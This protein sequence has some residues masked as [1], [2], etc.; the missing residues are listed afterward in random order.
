[1]RA[2]RRVWIVAA[3]AVVLV[4][5]LVIAGFGPLV[6]A[7]AR[8]VAARRGLVALVGTARP[9]WGRVW[10]DDVRISIP[11]VPAV[12]VRLN[13]VELDLSMFLGVERII[14]HGGDITLSGSPDEVAEQ[15]R[16][17]RR[18][19]R[20]GAGGGVTSAVARGLHLTWRDTAP[21]AE[22][23]QVWGL[24][25]SRAENG[26][27]ALAAELVRVRHGGVAVE[28]RAPRVTF[29]RV[30]GKRVLERLAADAVSATVALDSVLRPASEA[31]PPA[32]QASAASP[33]GDNEPKAPKPKQ[34]AS[35]QA[36][37]EAA[38]RAQ[39]E[40]ARRGP[41]LRERLARFAAA[42]DEVLPPQSELDL[43][44]LRLELRHQGERMRIGPARLRFSRDQKRLRLSLVP[45]AGQQRAPL[46]LSLNVPFG[47]GTVRLQL[48]GGPVSL[49]AL[50]VEEGNFGLLEVDQ[51]RVEASGNMELGKDG[52]EATFT[53]RGQLSNLSLAHRWLARE[54]LR[55]INVSWRGK[56]RAALDG[57]RLQIDESELRV[58][59]VRAELSGELVR[60]AEDFE[61]QLEGGVPLASCQDLLDSLP[62]PLVPKLA[63]M[64]LA[65]TFSLLAKLQL[66]TRR[67]ADL[68]LS[69]NIGNECRVT[70]VPPAID[71]ANFKQAFIL[72]ARGADGRDLSLE[73]GPGSP[74]WVSLADISRHMETAVIVCEDAH[75]W[76]HDGFDREAIENSI[77]QNIKA[78]ELVRGASTISMQ[79][80]KNLYLDRE[81]TLARKLQEA[82]LTHLLEQQLSKGEILE[83]YLNIVEFG[84]GI[85]GV[86]PAARHYFNSTPDQLSIGQAVYLASIMP[87]PTQQHFGADGLV[88]P[89]WSDYLRRLMR[90]AHKIKRLSDEELE[91]GLREQVAFGTPYVAPLGEELLDG[92]VLAEPGHEN[93]PGESKPNGA[94][95]STVPFD[96]PSTEP[97]AP[98]F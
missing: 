16:S 28:M 37:G 62:R 89:R 36:P 41:L 52:R 18:P 19:G 9:G 86:G 92:A 22:P 49:A 58:G 23:G 94:R 83:L 54:P 51:A 59:A 53:G 96:Q 91:D 5:I 74:N 82:V 46:T 72:R 48:E 56:G 70:A 97:D 43:S 25:Y 80:A 64:K 78:K 2:R 42:V 11:G 26:A 15:L 30:E 24:R 81:K 35:K 66:D 21:G 60:D 12:S 6:R 68:N 33:A 44:G 69:W 63:G 85:Y 55:R 90:I 71:P 77:R 8:G 93:V 67:P 45:G 76:R 39:V 10:L 40:A 3:V 20:S 98:E 95:P 4:A 84:P 73:T 65:G 27:E 87:A 34:E 1:M 7:R 31:K 57:S 13:V 38:K 75:F 17:W 32:P 88:T 14:V 50:G 47:P 79:L 29:K 61:L